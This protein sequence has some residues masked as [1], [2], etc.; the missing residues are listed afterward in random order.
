MV[1]SIPVGISIP[2]NILEQIDKDR[3]DVP[4]SRYLL[5]VLERSYSNQKE[6]TDSSASRIG[7]LETD[8]S[9][10]KVR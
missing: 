5:R 3:K 6:Q 9:F 7:A 8:E 10:D 2:E 4:R 1:K